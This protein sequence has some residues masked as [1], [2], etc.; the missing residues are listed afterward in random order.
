MA[1]SAAPVTLNMRPAAPAASTIPTPAAAAATVVQPSGDPQDS[2][3]LS[4][5]L[6][7]PPPPNRQQVTAAANGGGALDDVAKGL[8]QVSDAVTG[9]HKVAEV[10]GDVGGY[11][12]RLDVGR[13]QLTPRHGVSPNLGQG[14][15][16]FD[17][18][19]RVEASLFSTGLSRTS[20]LGDGWSRSQGVRAGVHGRY[21]LDIGKLVSGSYTASDARDAVGA[22][23][24]GEAYQNYTKQ[25]GANG[26]VTVGVQAGVGQNLLGEGTTAYAQSVQQFHLRVPQTSAIFGGDGGLTLRAREG[27]AVDADGARG[28]YE[29]FAGVTQ[30]LPVEMLGKERQVTVGV[31]AQVQGVNAQTPTVRPDVSFAVNF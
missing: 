15:V 25:V 7:D 1:D 11:Q 13:M 4:G 17:P 10:S 8:K 21:D 16:N 14:G 24:R 9:E 2:V 22:E 12:G 6:P 23:A 29:G 18:T 30:T 27:M 31:G 5:T 19:L 28:H 20:E 26:Q 3:E